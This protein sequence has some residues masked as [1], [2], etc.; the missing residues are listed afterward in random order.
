MINI[1]SLITSHDLGSVE[2]VDEKISE[3]KVTV[4]NMYHELTEWKQQHNRCKYIFIF[5][6]VT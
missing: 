2:N 3:I 5:C 6:S 1:F 4:K